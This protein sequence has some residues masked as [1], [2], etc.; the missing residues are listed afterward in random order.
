[1]PPLQL[2]DNFIQ[3]GSESTDHERIFLCGDPEMLKFWK[4]YI[5]GWPIEPLKSLQNCSFSYKQ[6]I[7]VYL[8]WNQLAV[9]PIF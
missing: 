1:M 4:N 2:V 6:F 5:S 3:H 7:L 8:V 9:T